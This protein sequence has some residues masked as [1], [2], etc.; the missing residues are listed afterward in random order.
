MNK[1]SKKFVTVFPG[2]QDY[3]F[4]KD[5]GQIPYRFSKLGYLSSVVF[6]S[7][8]NSFF[9]SEKYID[10]VK[11]PATRFKKR[12]N[13]GI[14]VYLLRNCRDIRVLNLFHFTWQSLL[15]AFVFKTFNPR[16]FVYLKMDASCYS[17]TYQW[18][19]IFNPTIIPS[20]T[21]EE[22]ETFKSKLK[23]KIVSRYFVKKI[24]LW[25]VEDDYTRNIYQEHY[26]FFKKK[27][28][29]VYNGHAADIPLIRE[30]R[31]F[32]DKDNIILTVGRLGT[33]QK[34]TDILLEAFRII[35]GNNNY[36]LHLAG[37]VEP[38]F[39]NE[40]NLFFKKN[41]ELKERIIFH[42]ILNREALYDLYNRSKIFCM[43]SLY[44]GMAIV[45]PEAMYF[46]NATVTTPTVS[47]A[48]LISDF[49][50]GLVAEGADPIHVAEKL[51]ILINDEHLIRTLAENAHDF[52]ST[53]FNWDR[54]VAELEGE[55]T[56]RLV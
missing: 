28:V 19:K 17:G 34:G 6:Y 10:L 32:N 37:S 1:K 49:K 54:I 56:S 9:E 7:D 18:E 46:R 22:K 38:G 33:Y 47:P 20:F 25:S 39:E 51:Q 52:S 2:Y 42:G 3:H 41:P 53:K 35:T 21:N 29:T 13:Q 50:L 16:G 27:L 40:I 43:P 26:G 4:Y 45:F 55:I 8:K 12:L 31:Q 30:A 5:P 48:G 14:L 44:D 23:N 36:E 15:F 24:D 11:I